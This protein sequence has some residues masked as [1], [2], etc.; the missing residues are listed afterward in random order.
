VGDAPAPF[1]EAQLKGI[2]GVEIEIVRIE[3]KW[4]ASQN[5]PAAD[6]AGVGKGLRGE[7]TEGAAAMA[8]LV[9]AGGPGPR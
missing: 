4:K 1:V 9:E 8:D 6:R 7:G 2:V 5:R 3:G